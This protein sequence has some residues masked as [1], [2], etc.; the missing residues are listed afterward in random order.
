MDA[1]R[2]VIGLAAPG[3]D[4]LA[5]KLLLGA[6]GEGVK[7][8]PVSLSVCGRHL[9]NVVRVEAGAVVLGRPQPPGKLVGDRAC[10]PPRLSRRLHLLRGWSH[11]QA[12]EVLP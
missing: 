1:P 5:I 6:T 8:S 9:A 3:T 10:E 11:E 2:I 12:N 4:T 7:C